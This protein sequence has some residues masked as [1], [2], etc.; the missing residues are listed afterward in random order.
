MQINDN[1]I[2]F[3]DAMKIA[4]IDNVIFKHRSNGLIV[5]DYQL[6]V[7][8]RCGINFFNYSSF[9]ELLFDIEEYLYDNYDEELDIIS[10]QIAELKYYKDTKK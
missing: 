1:N 4:D 2:T 6:S 8:E 5:S 9:D 10:D 3:D 7:L